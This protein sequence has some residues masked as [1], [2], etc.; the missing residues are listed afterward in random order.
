M[1]DFNKNY[2]YIK[3][4]TT[5]WGFDKVTKEDFFSFLGNETIRPYVRQ[6]YHNEITIDEVPEE[7]RQEVETVV[8]NR[9]ARFGEYEAKVSDS[10]A[11]AEIME[12]I[13]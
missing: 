5:E 6:V 8:N 7:Y 11:L 3:S 10:Q 13:Q 9:I 1:L 12:V 4:S 2:Y